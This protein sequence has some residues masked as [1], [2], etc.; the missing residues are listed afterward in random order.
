ML[1][2]LQSN[3]AQIPNLVKHLSLPIFLFL[4]FLLESIQHPLRNLQ[5][6]YWIDSPSPHDSPHRLSASEP[7]RSKTGSARGSLDLHG[8][9]G[10]GPKRYRVC[11]SVPP[12]ALAAAWAVAAVVRATAVLGVRVTSAVQSGAFCS[13]DEEGAKECILRVTNMEVDGTC[14]L[15][16]FHPN[17]GAVFRTADRRTAE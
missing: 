1:Q 14:L 17:L 5:A 12:T 6:G 3:H 2:T 7:R 15:F 8:S 9:T 11:V 16:V 13:S 10:R 4:P